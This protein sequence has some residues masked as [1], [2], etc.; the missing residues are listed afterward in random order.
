M[1][2]H[3]SIKIGGISTSRIE[4]IDLLK[5]WIAISL[6]FAIVF[7]RGL[8]FDP[9]F[10]IVFI[11]A[12]ITVGTG[13]LLHEMA[14]KLV[15]QRY[16]CFAEFRASDQMLLIAIALAVVFK[17]IFAAPGAV[18]IAGHV[19]R[20]ENG[21]ISVAG[22]WTNIVISLIFLL[23]GLLLPALDIVWNYGFRINTWLA[24]FNM[25]PL[26]VL[27]GKKVW[28]WNK[29]VWLSTVFTILVLMWVF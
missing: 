24:L 5:A 27:D 9:A 23:L 14:H 17:A 25:I 6:A 12:A 2:I 15:A 28:I 4:L 11:V 20:R 1:K 18:M 22:P 19:T 10:L 8:S 29:S 7:N 16:G 3:K 26:W 21:F 13:F